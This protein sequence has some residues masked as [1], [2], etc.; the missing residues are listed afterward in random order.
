[1]IIPPSALGVLLASIAGI[2]VGKLLIA[3]LLP[4]ITLALLYA[5]MITLQLWMNP[6]SAPSYDVE[7]TT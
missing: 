6:D 7:S 4:G 3:G 1:M 2:D 5:A